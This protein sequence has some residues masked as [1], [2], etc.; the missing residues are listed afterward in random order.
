MKL[1]LAFRDTS[2]TYTCQSSRTHTSILNF[3]E[4]RCIALINLGYVLNTKPPEMTGPTV[5]TNL[6]YKLIAFL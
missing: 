2:A 5:E 1:V 3:K 6:E 4:T